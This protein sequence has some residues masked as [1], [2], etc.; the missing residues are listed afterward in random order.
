MSAH[1]K[2]PASF[3]ARAALLLAFWLG[4]AAAPLAAS[5]SS[6]LYPENGYDPSAADLLAEKVIQDFS[7]AGYLR[8]EAAIPA[9][10]S[11][12]FDVRQ[13]PYEAD[14]TGTHDATAAIQ[15]AINAAG[16]AGGGVVFLPAGTY[17]LSVPAGEEQALLLDKNGV[18]LRGAGRGQTYLRNTTTAM[19]G[20]SVIR[21]RGPG[22]AGFWEEGSGTLSTP[23][24]ADLLRSVREIPVASVAGFAPGDTVVVR[25]TITEAWITEEKESGWTGF[26]G[27]GSLRG[28]AYRRTVVAVDAAANI[29]TVDAPI[30][31]ALKLRDSAR[32]VRLAAAP[33]SGVGLEDFSFANEQ[34]PGAG[35]GED[36]YAIEGTAAYDVHGSYFIRLNNVRDSWMARLSSYQPAGNTSTAHV[37]SGGISIREATHVTVED[38]SIQR[39]QY[40]GAGG[41]GYLFLIA[42][43]GEVLLQRNEAHFSRHGYSI[44]GIGASGN[45]LHDC[46]DADTGRATG[47]VG[48]YNAGGSGSDHHMH[49][50]QA[51]LYD[52][53]TG[54]NS[55]FEARYRPHG[56]DPKHNL[57]AVHSVFWNTEGTGTRGDAVVRSEQARHGYVIGTR[58]VRSGVNRPRTAATR[59]DPI[60]HLEGEG[61]GDTLAP[62]SLFLDQRGRR[63]GPDFVLPTPPVLSHPADTVEIT[64]AA[65]GFTIAGVPAAA[66]D[67]AITWS[68][69]PAVVL[70]PL[71]GG[72]VRARVPGPGA[73]RLQ[74]VLTAGGHSRVRSITVRAAP[75]AP[76]APLVAPAIAD[77]FIEGDS[78]ANTNNGASTLVRI[79]WASTNRTRR[80]GLLR[81]DLSGLDLNAGTLASARLVLTKTSGATYAGWAIDVRSV[82]SSPAW[83]ETGVTWN[84]APAIGTTL[85]SYEPSPGLVDVIDLTDAVL[86]ARTAGVDA[87]DLA[88][89]VVSQPD[90]SILSYHSR[91]QTQAD[92]RPRL[93]L[94]VL[95]DIARFENWIAHQPGIASHQLDPLDDPDGDGVPNLLEMALG[96]AP[97]VPDGLPPLA[98]VDGSLRFTLAEIFP[99]ATRLRLEQSTDLSTWQPVDIAS[100]HIATDD[101]GLLHITRPVPIDAPRLFWRL[102]I[103]PE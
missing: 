71:H 90:V 48:S 44:T 73:W 45:V 91:E 29:L 70:T 15:A 42:N 24:A 94:D 79:K 46:L 41:N 102:R 8:G 93:E 75:S 5:W 40:G 52:R 62:Q 97:G 87:L 14:F 63:L 57:T 53:C 3:P 10:G 99:A 6:V 1:A 74:A 98:W 58:G 56:S 50:S 89:F 77:T 31:Y 36:D 103:D 25:N 67:M 80:H 85:A 69:P 68:A 11:P 28:L 96:R 18:V 54:E 84:N 12:I 13:A 19:R 65:D 7:Y 23:L 60:D 47:S 35:W 4:L 43:S 9:V 37:L 95:P 2:T 33:L 59:T 17:R 32:V 101:D 86:A 27:T 61:Q 21:V 76:P 49:F 72:A 16:L 22:G 30:R 26:A 38:C 88:L 20:K 66:S 34:H 100:D 81:F 55:W 82:A 39:A 64:P 51:N 78:Q 83:T 92:L